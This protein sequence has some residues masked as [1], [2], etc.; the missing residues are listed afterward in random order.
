LTVRTRG[1]LNGTH[2][3]HFRRRSSAALAAARRQRILHAAGEL[4]RHAS[5]E[6]LPIE[7]IIRR[8]GIGRATFYRYFGSKEELILE[9]FEEALSILDLRLKAAADAAAD[10]P[11]ELRRMVEALIEVQA[12]H[13]APLRLLARSRSELSR[14]WREALRAMR[15]RVLALLRANLQRGMRT[16]HYRA[17]VDPEATPVLLNGMVRAGLMHLPE[18]PVP[19]LVG[20]I[21]ALLLQGILAEQPCRGVAGAARPEES[22]P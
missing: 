22:L 12:E 7:D 11:D 17:D 4:L 15:A 16:G 6:A 14:C 1:C 8:A 5:A 19:R 3:F 2:E 21:S 10:P 13:F 20:A 9:C 18:V